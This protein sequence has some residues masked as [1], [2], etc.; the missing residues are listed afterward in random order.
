LDRIRRWQQE[1]AAPL[2]R[3][4][5]ELKV[6]AVREPRVAALRKT[7]KDAELQAEVEGLRRLQSLTLEARPKALPSPRPEL[8]E[9]LSHPLQLR[10]MAHLCLLQRL[11][12]SIDPSP[13]AR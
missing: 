8:A 12:A 13:S 2:R 10:E 7:L 3:L 6:E 4:R 9:Y 11:Q 1:F 5:R